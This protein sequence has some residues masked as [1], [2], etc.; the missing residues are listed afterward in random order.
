MVY[1]VQCAW[2]G[3]YLRT[4]QDDREAEKGR[5]VLISH[6]ICRVCR[7]RESVTFKR[8]DTALIR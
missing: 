3:K 1:R 2:C 5:E 7:R 6:G 8:Q 4:M